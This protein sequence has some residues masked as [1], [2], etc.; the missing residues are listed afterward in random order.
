[1]PSLKIV[2]KA[3]SVEDN[4]YLE[5]SIN[6]FNM[7]LTGIPFGGH[8]SVLVYD[9]HDQRI[10]GVT[11]WQWGDSFTI[12]FLWLEQEWRG[13]DIGTEIMRLIEHQAAERGCTQ[14]YLDTYSF[15]AVDFYQKLG[16]EAFGTLENFPT[17]YRRYFLRKRLPS[18]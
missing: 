7:D 3:P 17:P 1:M 5:N 10:G 14:I 9:E 18:H 6:R 2:V 11:G 12:E 4:A 8:V 13:Q 15:Q 16:Y